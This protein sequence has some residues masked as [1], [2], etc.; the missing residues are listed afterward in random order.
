MQVLSVAHKP[1]A[2]FFYSHILRCIGQTLEQLELKA[3]EI[4]CQDDIYFVQGWQKAAAASVDLKR[5][6][7]LDDLNL[8][9]LELREQRR[10]GSSRANPFRL[11]QFLRT[12]GHYVDYLGA[13]LLRVEWQRQSDKVQCITLQYEAAEANRE[14][15]DSAPGAIEEICIHIYKERKKMRPLAR[16]EPEN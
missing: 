8:L 15:T 4:K 9:E 2:E 16:V 11:S 13:R 1:A 5:R 10:P 3:F 12:A 14:A 6:Y 7:T